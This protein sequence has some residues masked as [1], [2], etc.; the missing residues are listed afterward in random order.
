MSSGTLPQVGPRQISA[1]RAISSALAVLL[2]GA[3]LYYSLRGI[4]WR[5][6]WILIAGAK[7]AYLAFCCALSAVALFL[8]AMRW[9]ILL[10]AEADIGVGAAFW[11]TSAGYFGNNFLPA[12]AGELVRTFMISSRS[13]LSK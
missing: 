12:R 9:R 7:P 6:V 10:R 5:Q 1:S 13:G 11:A 3:L 2:A 4:E 8:R